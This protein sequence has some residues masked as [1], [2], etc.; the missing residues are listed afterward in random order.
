MQVIGTG[1]YLPENIITNEALTNMVDTTDKWIEER[2]GI[3]ERHIS[4]GEEDT[5]L[6][7]CA[8]RF[9]LE[10]SHLQPKDIGLIIV[11]TVTSN[12]ITPSIACVVQ[13]TL[14]IPN[15]I[16]FDIN[17]ACTG[18]VY[19]LNTAYCYLN[20]G[21]AEY[22]LIIGTET[23]SKV[24]DYTDRTTCVL[25]G[26]G[27]GAVV[28]R[29]RKNTFFYSQIG[30]NGDLQDVIYCKNRV[31]NNCVINQ[32]NTLDYVHMNGREV[33]K[34][35]VK[36]IP[37]LINKVLAKSNV[38]IDDVKYFVLHQA[39]KRMNEMVARKIGVSFEK[40]PCNLEHVGNTSAASI[41]ILLDEMNKKEMLK[42]GDYIVLCSFGAGMTWGAVLLKW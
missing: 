15:A 7:I 37:I 9:A 8:G 34:F 5:E 36:Q 22:A 38:K 20:S 16:A 32:E 11:A 25:F 23:L 42:C 2:T 31:L 33:Y 4:S 19:G 12:Y 28:V 21:M 27:A 30:A 13:E 17:A 26:D 24:I 14:D 10:N 41:P 3:M 35:V 1:H 6:A 40:F 18:F 39:N 29:K